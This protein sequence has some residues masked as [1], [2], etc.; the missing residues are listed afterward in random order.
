MYG[1]HF[2]PGMWNDVNGDI[3]ANGVGAYVCS[4]RHACSEPGYMLEPIKQQRCYRVAGTAKNWKE[5]RDICRATDD[6]GLGADLAT[7][8]SPEEN[9]FVQSLLTPVMILQRTIQD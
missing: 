7:I 2:Q 4:F 3:V 6:K 1:G 8:T 5:A 9:A